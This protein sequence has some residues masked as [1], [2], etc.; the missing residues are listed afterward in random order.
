[1]HTTLGQLVD[2]FKCCIFTW[3]FL[4]VVLP[5]FLL[6]GAITAFVPTS[7]ILRYLG[8]RANQLKAYVVATLGGFVL[9]TCSCNIVPISLSVYR[10]GAGIGPAFA[11][12]FCGPAV[13]IVTLAWTFKIIG[14]KMGLWR[15]LSTPVIGLLIGIIMQLLFRQDIGHKGHESKVALQDDPPEVRANV[16]TS[17]K[18]EHAMSVIILLIGIMLLGAAGLPW[19]FRIPVLFVFTVS[20][21]VVL[22][23]W[24]TTEH[25]KLWMSE[26]WMFMKSIL[27]ILV[28]AILAIAFIARV[29]PIRWITE[30]FS[31][32][33]PQAT[34]MAAAFGSLMYFPI[35]TEV[36]FAKA[37]LKQG[38]AVAPALAILL[39]GPGVSL[40]GAILIGKLFGLKKMLVYELLEMF[41]S[42]SVALLFGKL[43]GDY[44]CPCQ[45]GEVAPPNV[46][47]IIVMLAMIFS[48]LVASFFLATH[49][50]RER[51]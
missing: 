16:F 14:F 39:N 1:M 13:N 41:F 47:H 45:V 23:S 4:P 33:T 36:A 15:M 10:K 28:P 49:R 29:I 34:F 22:K 26:T 30:Y 51:I 2:V 17:V 12:L 9:S 7:Q 42:G 50:K 11:F 31:Q 38:M 3:D 48:A 44:V 24:F 20:L 19:S 43:Y 6:A 35:L 8:H 46:W 37:F 5:A 40:P 21:I 18:M 25:I 32:N 27:P